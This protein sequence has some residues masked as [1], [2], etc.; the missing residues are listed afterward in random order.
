MTKSR[1]IKFT[2]VQFINNAESDTLYE[3][4]LEVKKLY[5]RRGFEINCILMDGQFKPI[6][7]QLLA[8]QITLNSTAADEHVSEIERMIR[9]VKGRVR[10]VYTNVPFK[11]I[12]GRMVIELVYAAVFW[13]NYFYPSPSICD[14]LSPRTIMT[15]HTLDFNRHCKHEFGAYV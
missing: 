3:S 7:L 2:T 12:P 5:R 6:E 8:A 15:G 4:I 1:H 9:V 14:N 10:G 11:R 13:L